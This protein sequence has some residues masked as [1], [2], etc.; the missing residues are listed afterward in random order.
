MSASD[1]ADR[2]GILERLGAVL[3]ESATEEVDWST[4]DESTTLESFGFDSLAVL[5]LI[6]DLEQEFGVQI[7]AETMIRMKTVGDLVTFLEESGG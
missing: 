1:N 6:F 2:A 5:D 7:P 3:E 4:V